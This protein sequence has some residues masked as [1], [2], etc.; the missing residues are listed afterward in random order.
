MEY[1]LVSSLVLFREDAKDAVWGAGAVL[2]LLI[3][4]LL[5]LELME[6]LD[7]GSEM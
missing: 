3:M 4:M 1:K 6:L 7:N 5:L 2:L